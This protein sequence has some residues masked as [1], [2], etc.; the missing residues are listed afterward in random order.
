MFGDHQPAVETEFYEALY[1]TSEESDLSLTQEYYKTP[2]VLWANYDIEEETKDLS[3]NQ[4]GILA[5]QVA[6]VSLTSYD[7]FVVDFSETIPILNALGYQD[8]DGNWWSLKKYPSDEYKQLLTNY[9][10]VQYRRYCEWNK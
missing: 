6:G 7:Q 5:K 1:G 2:Y 9:S 3:A 8:T 4:L 10:Y